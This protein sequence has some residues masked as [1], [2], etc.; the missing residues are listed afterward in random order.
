VDTV[1]SADGTPIAFVREGSGPALILVDGAMCYSTN[2]PMPALAAR[3]TDHFTVYRYDRRG[4]GASGDTLPYAVDREIEDLVAL[5]AHA[6]GSAFACGISSG[7]ALVLR[8]AAAGV[9]WRRLALFEV[10]YTGAKGDYS[11]ELAG[12]LAAGR[13]GDAVARFM[14][15]VGMPA[16]VVSGMRGSPAWPAFEA[17]APTLGYDDAVL[18]DG[19]VPAEAGAV[20]VPTLVLDGGASP[21][22]LRDASAALAAAVPDAEH[23]TLPDQTHDVSAD[24]LAPVLIDF[25]AKP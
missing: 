9:P 22:S 21:A 8:S 2:G 23:G 12:L 1:T 17:I 15:Q 16:E 6:G 3:L 19:S 11:A 25:F 13:R 5:V 24:A 18:G 10:P 4:R 14:T 20:K 7:G